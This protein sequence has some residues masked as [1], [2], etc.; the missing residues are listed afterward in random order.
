SAG[1]DSDILMDPNKTTSL[2]K[3]V[4]KDSSLRTWCAE[5]DWDKKALRANDQKARECK[6]R[7]DQWKQGG[8]SV[9]GWWPA[10]FDENLMYYGSGNPGTWNP[11][12]RPGDN[13]WSMTIFARDIDTGMARWVYQMTPHDEWDYDGV[14]E[15]ILADLEIDGETRKTLVHFDRNGFGYTLDRVTG[16]LLVAEK[17]DPAVNWATHVDMETGRP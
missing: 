15:M 14:N 9:W 1:P 16:E 7:G 17:Y 11:V 10:D 8:G 5:G 12:V 13:K 3:P 4:G 2:G 6:K